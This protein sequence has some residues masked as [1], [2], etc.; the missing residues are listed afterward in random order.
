M[1]GTVEAL[2]REAAND[3]EAAGIPGPRAE[4]RLL[5]QAAA[6]RPPRR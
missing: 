2:L 6:E 5:L 3:L 1:T 4:A